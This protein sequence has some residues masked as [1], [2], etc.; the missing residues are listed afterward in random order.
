MKRV[1][2]KR[3]VISNVKFTQTDKSEKSLE[4]LFIKPQICSAS[5]LPVVNTSTSTTSIEKLSYKTYISKET[6]FLVKP[7]CDITYPFRDNLQVEKFPSTSH[8]FKPQFSSNLNININSIIAKRLPLVN[9]AS[10][11]YSI[12][13][14]PG[15]EDNFASTTHTYSALQPQKNSKSDC[16]HSDSNDAL[17]LK[18]ENSNCNFQNTKSSST[19]FSTLQSSIHYL[20]VLVE[21]SQDIDDHF[22]TQDGALKSFNNHDKKRTF[23]KIHL[24][25][26][27]YC[28]S[29]SSQFKSTETFPLDNPSN[30]TH[31]YP[32]IDK[33]TVTF[34]ESSHSNNVSDSSFRFTEMGKCAENFIFIN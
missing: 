18:K 14:F 29:S 16:D 28:E 10:S 30:L 17:Y 21:K 9:S 7:S 22:L 26:A 3:R 8:S 34:N 25:P 11:K 2:R 13:A 4:D 20:P 23:V 5:N 12:S 6:I 33:V 19:L 31:D 15:I 1:K 32:D 27:Q 24:T